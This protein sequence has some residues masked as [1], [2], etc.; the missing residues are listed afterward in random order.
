MHSNNSNSIACFNIFVL[1]INLMASL[2]IFF[3]P[4]FSRSEIYIYMIGYFLNCFLSIGLP[5]GMII[6]SKVF[7]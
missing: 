3:G 6:D 4:I 1:V 7:I 5:A 2:I